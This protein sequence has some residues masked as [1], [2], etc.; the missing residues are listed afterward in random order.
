MKRVALPQQLGALS[1]ALAIT[2]SIVWAM[3]AY[4]YGVAP[5]PAFDA[6]AMRF[7]RTCS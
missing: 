2:F 4:A 5:P 1:V 3:S 6:S 7:A